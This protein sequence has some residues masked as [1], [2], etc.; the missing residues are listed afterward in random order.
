MVNSKQIRAGRALLNWDLKNLSE[1]A[2]L[3]IAQI[4]DIENERS[5]GSQKSLTKIKRALEQAGVEFGENYS[6]SLPPVKYVALEQKTWFSEILDDVLITLEHEENKELLIFGG[7]N[8]VSPPIV[9]E[10]IRRLREAGVK[11]REMVCEGDTYLM[12]PEEEY[13][14]IPKKLYKNYITVLYSNKVCLDFKGRAIMIA[15]DKWAATEKNKFEILWA[16]GLPITQESTAD[17]R[18]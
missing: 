14:W 9:I 5:A 4:S 17:V 1:R 8:S 7:N 6:V 11:I 3:S 16:A 15:N 18:Y 13:R 10:K 2:S 12:G